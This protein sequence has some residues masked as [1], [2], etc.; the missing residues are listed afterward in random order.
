MMS[1]ERRVGRLGEVRY[2]APLGTEELSH[3]MGAIRDI[4]RVSE[5]PL[6][7]CTDWRSLA[8]FTTEI[9]DTIVWI[10]RRDNPNIECNG[11]IL[12]PGRA[13]FRR[14]VE[15]ITKQ[16]ANVQRRL[17]EDV[18]LAR[19]WLTPR[20]TELEIARLDAFIAEGAATEE[21]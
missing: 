15:R 20:L 8:G 16:A 1:V 14:Q 3:F 6:V 19:D 11:I 9:A 12:S 2:R 13:G 21:G 18:A 4:V 17:F 10:M 5:R 7:F